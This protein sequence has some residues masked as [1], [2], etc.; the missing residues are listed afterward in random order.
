MCTGKTLCEQKLVRRNERQRSIVF[1]VNNVLLAGAAS[2]AHA[3][4]LRSVGREG[5]GAQATAAQR[6]KGVDNFWWVGWDRRGLAVPQ[7]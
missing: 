1:A 3:R 5:P 4:G 2:L 7:G 6:E